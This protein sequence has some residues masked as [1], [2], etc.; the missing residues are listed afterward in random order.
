[1]PSDAP[2]VRDYL[3]QIARLKGG[4]SAERLVLDRGQVWTWAPLPEL[5]NYGP[6]KECFANAYGALFERGGADLLYVEGFA[7]TEGLIVT[8]HA[9][10]GTADGL[11][12]DVTWRDPDAVEAA[13]CGM[14]CGSG[15]EEFPVSVG[16][17][18]E[19][20][21][22]EGDCPHCKGSGRAAHLPPRREDTEYLGIAFRPAK[23]ARILSLKGTYGLLDWEPLYKDPAGWIG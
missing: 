16:G 22:R 1:M 2:H 11:A 13:D 9:W 3:E 23:A 7:Y 12:Y 18:G 21:W 6:V 4:R 10:L 8:E 5:L 20:E 15:K 17:G 19:V 14:C